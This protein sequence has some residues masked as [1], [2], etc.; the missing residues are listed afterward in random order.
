LTLFI[1]LG[2]HLGINFNLTRWARNLNKTRG[3]GQIS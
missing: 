2:M 1:F 3:H